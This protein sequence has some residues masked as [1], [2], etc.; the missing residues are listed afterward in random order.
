MA[1]QTELP[2][3]E[4]MAAD[5][6]NPALANPAVARC[7]AAWKRTYDA[8]VRSG[9]HFV[10]AEYEASKVYRYNMPPLTGYQE[11]A[12]YITCVTYGMAMAAIVTKEGTRLLYAAQVAL[13]ALRCKDKA[14]TEKQSVYT[15]PHPPILDCDKPCA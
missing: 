4:R 9:T 3:T 7:C 12:D 14:A 11:I 8:E 15:P 1:K 2:P 6:S 5:L 10:V 13:A